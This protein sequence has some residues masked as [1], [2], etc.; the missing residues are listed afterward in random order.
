MPDKEKKMQPNQYYSYNLG[1][2]PL[3]C[4]Y[5]VKGKKLVVFVTGVCPRK[6]YFC[7]VSDDKSGQDNSFANERR[8]EC[9]GGKGDNSNDNNNGLIKE[10][11]LMAAKG[12]GITGGDPLTQME[13]TVGFIRLLKEKFGEKNKLS[14]EDDS[15]KIFHIHLY[16]SLNLVDEEKLR[17]LSEAGLDEIRFHLDL[18]DDKLWQKIE[19]ASRYS[20]DIGVEIPLLPDKEE[21]IKKMIDFIQDKVKFLNLNELERADNK[22]SKLGEM[23]FAVREKFSYA[24]KDSL[25]LGL[26]LMDY[27][28]SMKYDLPVH[29][30]TAKLKDKIQLTNRIKREGQHNHKSFDIVDEE[31]LLTRGALYLSDLAPGFGYR[32]KLKKIDKDE[33]VAK[34]KPLFDKIVERFHLTDNDIFLDAEKPRILLS[35][36]KV[37]KKAKYFKKLGLL[38][39]VVK[40]YPTADQLEIEVEFMK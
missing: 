39:A 7:P 13:R 23:G 8:I 19:L 9:G 27:V 34:L 12:A 5:C 1:E 30:C 36:K 21:E 11:E 20:W 26:K 3:G 37:E 18:D 2:L 6:C 16:T 14:K 28:Q 22:L 31:G 17:R 4:Q 24:I 33:F 15:D 40:E 29:L 25:E 32:E 38:P 35:S 10:A